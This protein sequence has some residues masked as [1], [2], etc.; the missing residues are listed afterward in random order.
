M[1]YKISF[2]KNPNSKDVQI[3][4][5]GI[6]NNAKLKTTHNPID[7]FG[8]FIHDDNNEIQGGCNGTNIYGCLYIDQLWIS[9]HLRGNG[10]GTKLMLEAEIFGRNQG[11]NFAAVN[12]M[13]WEALEFYKKLGYYVEFERHGFFKD[14]IF[15]FLRKNFI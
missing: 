4:S 6:M 3:I 9:E 1:N 8:C 13:N 2:E 12:T 5:D 11:C 10:Y 7:F 15:Y 14:S